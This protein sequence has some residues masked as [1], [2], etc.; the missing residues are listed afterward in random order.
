MV[1]VTFTNPKYLWFLIIIPIML[2]IHYF[3]LRKKKEKSLKFSNFS[4]LEKVAGNHFIGLPL[5]GIFRNGDIVMIFLRFISMTSLI[6]GLAGLIIWYDGS[7]SNYDFVFAIDSSASMLANDMNPNRVEA[8]KDSAVRFLDESGPGTKVGV[9][10]FAEDSYVLSNV[11]DDLFDVRS[12]IISIDGKLKGGTDLG[13]ALVTSTSL[14]SQ[15]NRKKVIILMTDGQTNRGLAVDKAINFTK[16]REITVYTIGIGS[17]QGGNVSGLF[18][19][20]LDE[21][22]LINI[23]ESTGGK[24]FRAKEKEDMDDAFNLISEK[25]VKNLSK[26]VAYIF[27]LIGISVLFIEWWLLSTV[28][29]TIP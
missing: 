7:S 5:A 17:T 13:T 16:S 20:Q 8:A 3:A 6:L 26:D 4:A 10:S 21:P 2:I 12:S 18:I 15:S 19:S 14:L 27:L 23:A 9:V 24:Y 28:Y 1:A 25:T 11:T 22:T 29:A